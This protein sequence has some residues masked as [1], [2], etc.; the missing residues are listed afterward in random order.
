M[1]TMKRFFALTI[2]TVLAGAVFASDSGNLKVNMEASEASKALVEI[3][4]MKLSNFE[5]EV[6]D[7]Y[8]ESLYEMTTVAP[9]NGLK[10]RMDFSQLDDGI[11]TFS[12]K[13]DKE[14]TI[15]TFEVDRGDVEIINSRKTIDPYF[16]FEKKMV[17]LSYLN[18][19]GEDVKLYVY[20]MNNRLLA[21]S[22]L[23]NGFAIHKAV[24]FSDRPWGDYSVVITNDYDVHEYDV[25]IR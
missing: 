17:K 11:Y 8:G 18:P 25:V 12:V 16:T 7:S 6:T 1:K 13:I 3:S 15:Q 9:A 5:I 23:G 22:E 21:E 2:A 10:K 20:D 24:D 4:S 19:Q 14:R